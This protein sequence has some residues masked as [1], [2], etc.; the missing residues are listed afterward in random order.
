M[1]ELALGA[2]DRSLYSSFALCFRVPL[3]HDE[4]WAAA[5]QDALTG[6]G[7][8]KKNDNAGSDDVDLDM[9]AP[10]PYAPPRRAAPRAPFAHPWPKR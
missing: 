2:V 7:A 8:A 3:K 6:A 4:L 10:V 1:R 9:A 5:A